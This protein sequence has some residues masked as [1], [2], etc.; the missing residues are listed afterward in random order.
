[1][2]MLVLKLE[3]DI[4]M[5]LYE[6]IY[7]KIRVDIT[8]GKLPVGMKLPS[9]RKLGEFLDVSQTTIEL[10]YG[11]LI[12]EGF[13]S[14]IPRKG[15]YVQAIEE[16]AYVRPI[17]NTKMATIEEQDSI[18]FD[19]SP[20]HI[21]TDSFPFTQW[22]KYAKEVIDESSKNLLLLGDPHGDIE[23]RQEI[24]RYLYHSRGVDCTPEQII[25]G[26]GT[27]QLMPLVIRI[28]GTG[29]TYAIEDPGYPLTHHVFFHNN[30]EAIPI[31]VDDEGIDVQSLQQS[32]A[33]IAYVTP[34]HQF[35]TGTVLS[36]ARRT[37]L[38]NWASSQEEHFIIEDDYDS[39]FRYAGRP[40]PSL[41]GMDK[42]D[43]VI[44]LS[45]FSKSLMPSLRIAYM[46][47]PNVLLE[48]Y[49]DAFIHYAS[50]VPR[51]DQHILARFMADGH[52][53]RHLNKMRKIYKRKLQ[54]LTETLIPY[55]PHVSFS[56]DEAGM[57][58]IV[59]VH[60]GESEQMLTTAAEKVG[61]RLYGLNSYRTTPILGEPSFLIGFGGLSVHSITDAINNLMRAWGI[62]KT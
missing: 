62:R 55:A 30:R 54:T 22:R 59:T 8:D 57:H 49:K 36:A 25:V 37:A 6:Q 32:D 33:T 61:I 26:S 42:G 17:K 52:F 11:Q 7:E 10:A 28:L 5:P 38:L 1:M 15:F 40:I 50:T 23:L 24:A 60:T 14:S 13:I 18:D 3:K 27:E 45:T 48:R 21:D 53:S 9:K 29:A 20:G 56:G 44:Y 41:Q 19:F 34:S 31:H 58:I 12:A 16:L 43:S 2:E 51:L 39:E 46:V 47:L 4:D 35:P